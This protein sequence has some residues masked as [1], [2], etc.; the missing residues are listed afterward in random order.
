VSN[1]REDG[2]SPIPEAERVQAIDVLRGFALFGI[3]VVNMVSFKAPVFGG[4]GL[5]R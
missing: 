3:L 5:Q 1:P 4:T 2:G